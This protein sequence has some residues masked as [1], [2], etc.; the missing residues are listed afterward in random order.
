MFKFQQ[1][2][3]QQQLTIVSWMCGTVNYKLMIKFQML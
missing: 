3:F 1:A 2:Y